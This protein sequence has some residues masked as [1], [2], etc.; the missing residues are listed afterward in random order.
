MSTSTV[1]LLLLLA[2]LAHS[3]PV[4]PWTSDQTQILVRSQ[5][6]VQKILQSLVQIHAQ[7]VTSSGLTFDPSGPAPELQLMM[8]QLQITPPPVPNLLSPTFSQEDCVRWMWAGLE[9]QQR[10]V[11]DLS[12]KLSA[13]S[14]LHADLSDLQAQTAEMMSLMGVVISTV[15]SG[16]SILTRLH[17][18]YDTEVAV[19]LTL[20]TLRAFCHDLSRA[21]RKLPQV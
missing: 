11:G 5:M 19:H 7:T 4:G 10:I 20:T 16:S 21:L 2:A 13:L 9:Q 15:Q 6:L 17:G 8:S 12:S 18:D 14:D 3:A 1:P